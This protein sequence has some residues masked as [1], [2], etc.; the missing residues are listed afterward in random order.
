MEIDK[1][2]QYLANP[3]AQNMVDKNYFDRTNPTYGTPFD[4]LKA[5]EISYFTA[6]ENIAIG[7]MNAKSVMI[8]W[9]N[10]DGK[11]V[12]FLTP[13]FTYIGV[14]YDENTWV[15]MFIGK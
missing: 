3:K 11:R 13:S 8:G 10:S 5:N 14:G 2:V 7:Y 12:N 15:Q 6:G 9:M 1:E 4:M